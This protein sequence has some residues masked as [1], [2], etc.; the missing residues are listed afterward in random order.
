[1]FSLVGSGTGRPGCWPS[2]WW[3]YSAA[4]ATG[5]VSTGEAYEAVFDGVVTLTGRCPG[6]LRV[7]I[8]GDPEVTLARVDVCRI[9][10]LLEGR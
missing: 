5:E 10:R 2:C 8:M 9:A 7:E 6:S 3:Y 1:M 4:A